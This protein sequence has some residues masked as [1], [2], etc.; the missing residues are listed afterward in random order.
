[1]M[2]I[3]GCSNS[4]DLAK[5]ISKNLKCDYSDLSVKKFPDGEL[6]LK[7]ETELKNQDVVLV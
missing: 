7:F 6:Y 5:N 3:I 4:R 1:M 2:L